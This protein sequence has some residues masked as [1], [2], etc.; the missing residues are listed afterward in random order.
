MKKI[1]LI[2]FL[3]ISS[4][5]YCQDS[6]LADV[7][8]KNFEKG[9]PDVKYQVLLDAV[10]MGIEGMGLLFHKALLYV[11]NRTDSLDTEDTLI[12]IALSSVKQLH[13]I[14]YTES[15]ND[16]WRLFMETGHTELRVSILIALGDTGKDNPVIIDKMNRW[17]DSRNAIFL[18]GKRMDQQVIIACVQALGRIGDPSSFSPVFATMILHYSALVSSTAKQALDMIKG[19][20]S[21]LYMNVIMEG[22]MPEKKQSLLI[23][24]KSTQLNDQ[25]KSRIAEFALDFALHFSPVN[26]D[27]RIESLEI[28]YIAAEFLS[29]NGWSNATELMIE[30]FNQAIFDLDNGRVQKSFLLQAIEGLGNMKTHEAAKRLTLYLEH[31]NS[32]TENE[33]VY[34]EQTVLAVIYALEHLGDRIANAALLYSRYL[35]YSDTVKKAAQDALRNLK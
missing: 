5:L 30:H 34:D 20:V 25:E 32:F 22:R 8:L 11:L 28:R 3:S 23:S 6:S 35:N 17:L 10:D 31:I 19:D 26:Q 15:V 4:L 27:A 24:I 16:L 1:F 29:E 7:F 9:S 13:A 21:Q 2:L 12:R 14:H 18:T 33:K